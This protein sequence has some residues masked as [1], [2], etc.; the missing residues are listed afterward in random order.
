MKDLQ[1]LQD[2][3][4]M[5]KDFLAKFTTDPIQIHDFNH[6]ND[7][8]FGALVYFY[9]NVRNHHKGKQITKLIYSAYEEMAIS[10]LEEIIQERKTQFPAMKAA[11][12]H[13]L[14][15]LEI[16][17][18]AVILAV[19]S[20]HRQLAFESSIWIMDEVK[21]RVP[22]F[23]KEYFLENGGESHHWVGIGE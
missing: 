1:D 14:G 6:L 22:I 20:P 21:K 2:V 12:I 9:G 11:L 10:T 19:A 18:T 13:R 16:G 17:E 3:Q 8:S 5:P 15:T 23:K 4:D 7:P